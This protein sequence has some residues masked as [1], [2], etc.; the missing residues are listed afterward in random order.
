MLRCAF[1]QLEKYEQNW[2]FRKHREDMERFEALS[3]LHT[4]YRNE[5]PTQEVYSTPPNSSTPIP[6][7]EIPVTSGSKIDRNVAWENF[8]RFNEANN[9]PFDAATWAEAFELYVD[10]LESLTQE[11]TEKDKKYPFHVSDVDKIENYES[12]NTISSSPVSLT[13]KTS[14]LKEP[15]FVPQEK[16]TSDLQ[17]HG[18]QFVVKAQVHCDMTNDTTK[19]M[20]EIVTR[21]ESDTDD[22]YEAQTSFHDQTTKQHLSEPTLVEQNTTQLSTPKHSQQNLHFSQNTSQEKALQVSFSSRQ[23]SHNS[24]EQ[25]SP[26]MFQ[27]PFPSPPSDSILS[28]GYIEDNY[29]EVNYYPE[30]DSLDSIHN[31]FYDL[32]DNDLNDDQPAVLEVDSTEHTMATSKVISPQNVGSG[33]GAQRTNYCF[34]P[35]VLRPRET[36]QRPK[37]FQY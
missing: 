8:V 13:S 3:S 26:D 1:L 10:D 28:D 5:R 12:M 19:N 20:A 17:Q 6:S 30:T 27:N 37:R 29:L 15:V 34:S 7:N 33:L 18:V 16:L 4:A 32:F 36:L 24:L 11:I 25:H 22:F 35:R 14:T 31:Y 21:V 9:I 23:N 2:Q